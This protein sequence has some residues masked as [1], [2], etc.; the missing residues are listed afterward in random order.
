[1]CPRGRLCEAEG[2]RLSSS[3]CVEGSVVH[4]NPDS[5]I[6]FAD[7]KDRGT[8]RTLAGN[9]DSGFLHF[10]NFFEGSL[11]VGFG[12]PVRLDVNRGAISRFNDMGDFRLDLSLQFKDIVCK[13]ILVK[14]QQFGKGSFFFF[15]HR[16][17]VGFVGRRSDF[18]RPL[19]RILR[20]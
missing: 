3:L 4:T 2:T 8:P 12:N 7:W 16:V 6:L 18:P 17:L 19:H 10:G 15:G 11:L 14:A 20:K 5:S 13:D 1:M 9:N